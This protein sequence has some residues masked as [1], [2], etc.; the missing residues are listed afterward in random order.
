MDDSQ[1]HAFEQYVS[2]KN[3]CI[4]GPAGS[5]KSFLIRRFISEGNEGVAITA[6]TGTAAVL[7]GKGAKTLHSWAGIGLGKKHVADLVADIRRVTPLVLRWRQASTLIID[8]SSMLTAEL[9]E[10]LEAIARSIRMNN[11]FFGGI[12]V[13]LVGDFYQLPPVGAGTKYCFESPL[14]KHIKV[15]QLQTIWRQQDDVWRNMLNEIRVGVCSQECHDKLM[16][17]MIEPDRTQAIQPTRLYCRRL[18]VDCINQ[19]EHDKLEGEEETW[20]RR[21]D[22]RGTRSGLPE[23]AYDKKNVDIQVELYEKNAQ[24]YQTLRLKPKDQ[25]MLVANLATDLGLCNGSRGVV[26]R[27][28]KNIPYVRF[29]NGI[30]MPIDYHEWEIGESHRQ[31]IYAQQIPLR[32]AY[33]LTIHKSQGMTLD[34]AEVDIGSAVFEHG[35][36]Y[37]ALSRIKS[38]DGLYIMGFDPSKIKVDMRVKTLF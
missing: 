7:L 9:F 23:I 13:V 10:K 34:C 17:R 1:K 4:T 38:L 18:D 32:L 31:T 22:I 19:R 37:V 30:E 14:W 15:V 3:L 21:I 16:E 36:T 5:G 6:T 2:R 26:T 25:V 35:Q 11:D 24:Y 29:L 27:I 28:E 8:E 20:V 33:A 12:Q